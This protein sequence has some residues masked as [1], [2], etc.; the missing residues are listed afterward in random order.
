MEPFL[1]LR[2]SVDGLHTFLDTYTSDLSP[3]LL[4]QPPYH[5]LAR[6]KVLQ[7]GART[8]DQQWSKFQEIFVELCDARAKLCRLRAM[9]QSALSPVSALPHEVLAKI[10][11]FACDIFHFADPARIY[12]LSRVC[13]DWYN[14]AIA[15]KPLWSFSSIKSVDDID[16]LAIPLE[17]CSAGDFTLSVWPRPDAEIAEPVNLK[18]LASLRQELAC[19]KWW[20][21]QDQQIDSLF[22][23]LKTSKSQHL[24][25]PSLRSLDIRS[26]DDGYILDLSLSDLPKLDL[27]RL[28][29]VRIDQVCPDAVQSVQTLSISDV[30]ITP[31][32]L[33]H[34]LENMPNLRSLHLED[35]IDDGSVPPNTNSSLP[36]YS[37]L[38]ELSMYECEEEFMWY[39]LGLNWSSNLKKVEL[40]TVT[41]EFGHEPAGT[42]WGEKLDSV[43][44]ME[45]ISSLSTC[46]YRTVSTGCSSASISTP[47]ALRQSAGLLTVNTV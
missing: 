19:L 42:P 22:D 32:V 10:F 41:G 8:L 37:L 15:H 29:R 23:I 12:K 45:S 27:L 21:H 31:R 30:V 3:V 6:R 40:I 5:R 4:T 7:Q 39:L 14:V 46:L 17:R 47:S 44:A 18:V 26:L 28:V 25:L 1:N 43:N 20:T 36:D 38:E 35:I 2:R 16:K 34:M 33:V 9:A 24:Q 11:G 13:R